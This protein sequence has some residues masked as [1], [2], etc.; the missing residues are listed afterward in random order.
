MLGIEQDAGGRVACS[1]GHILRPTIGICEDRGGGLALHAIQETVHVA[2]G[3]KFLK[4][5]LVFTHYFLIQVQPC[6]ARHRHEVG[7][8]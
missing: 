6:R 1:E 4:N 5:H 3:V 7:P 2:C 8:P